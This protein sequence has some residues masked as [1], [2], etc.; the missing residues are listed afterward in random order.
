MTVSI[1]YRIFSQSSAK[2]CLECSDSFLRSHNIS[3]VLDTKLK[4]L[5]FESFNSFMLDCFCDCSHSL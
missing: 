5:P 4:I 3:I 1:K 2:T